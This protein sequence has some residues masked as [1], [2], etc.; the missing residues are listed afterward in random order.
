ML[1]K[2]LALVAIASVLPLGC[3]PSERPWPSLSVAPAASRTSPG[4]AF[5]DSAI[6]TVA[7]TI[8]DGQAA[9]ARVAQSRCS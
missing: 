1:R 9:R 3:G 5:D 8:A 4:L 2:R 7:E 6:A